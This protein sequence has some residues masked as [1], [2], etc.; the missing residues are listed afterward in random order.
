[1]PATTTPSP[2]ASPPRRPT[3][4]WRLLAW[5]ALLLVLFAVPTVAA[6][7]RLTPGALFTGLALNDT[8]NWVCIA[9]MRLGQQGDWL[10]QNPFA[11]APHQPVFG[12][13]LY[14][15][16]CGHLARW[17]GMSLFAAYHAGRLLG[18]GLF[19]VEL[20]RLLHHLWTDRR[21]RRWAFL[22]VVLA[23][24]FGW[25]NEL[26]AYW[27]DARLWPAWLMP[28]DLFGIHMTTVGTLL[29]Y[30]HYSW[31]MWLMLLVYRLAYESETAGTAPWWATTAAVALAVHHPYD[32]VP[33]FTALGLWF[34]WRA[35][36][37]GWAS[38]RRATAI[39]GPALA[40][41]LYYFW[42]FTYH[43]VLAAWGKQ[44]LTRSPHPAVL[45]CAVGF[46][47][48]FAVPG[49][50]SRREPRA[51]WVLIGCW[52][53][54]QGV[55]VYAPVGWHAMMLMGL[56]LVLMLWGVRGLSV[57][58]DR[59]PTHRRAILAL[60]LA[61]VLPGPVMIL[62][63]EAAMP[64]Q[65]D[66]D[67]VAMS[68]WLAAEPDDG[69][70]VLSHVLTGNRL[71]GLT[72]RRVLLGHRV[73]TP[74]YD[75]YVAAAQAWYQGRLG[76]GWLHERRIGHVVWGPAERRWAPTPPLHRPPDFTVGRFEVWR[77]PP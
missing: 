37:Q 21:Q 10:Y 65:V 54:V 59:F 41:I 62:Q 49:F 23:S 2:V 50:R 57:L 3:P 33:V 38:I 24:G 7:W 72:G 42:V 32:C 22:I 67:E 58:G 30:A 39:L 4:D 36:T 9:S 25:V 8:D 63:R 40:P 56:P 27:G 53:V 69:R 18:T 75:T 16:L 34:L 14:F 5:V 68:R 28:I 47:L 19:L 29:R 48:L 1:M 61:L 64:L 74:H 76:D 71:V 6:W 77:L 73:P 17:T 20:D 52:T 43:P 46:A 12:L 26:N 60:A 55:L 11:H 70:L 15:L 51:L 44:H 45:A 13:Y 66:A 31:A 35:R